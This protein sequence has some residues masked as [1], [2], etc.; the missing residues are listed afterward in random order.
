[1][2]WIDK[3]SPIPL[4][5]QLREAIR[6]E[7]RSARLTPGMMLPTEMEICAQLDISRTTVR[8][9]ILDLA[10]EG[11]LKRIP[12][13]GTFVAES[14]S[15]PD[16]IVI[17]AFAIGD[18]PSPGTELFFRIWDGIDRAARAAGVHVV[19]RRS[20]EQGD[21][22]TEFLNRLSR[23]PSTLGLAIFTWRGVTWNQ[24]RH[25]HNR[26]FPYVLLNRFIPEHPAPSVTLD[27][28][29]AVDQAVRRLH[30][31]GHRR[32]L[33]LGL[34]NPESTAHQERE[35]GYTLAMDALGLHS[36][37]HIA[38]VEWTQST[39]HQALAQLL[40]GRHD[41][42]AVI[43]ASGDVAANLVT[44]A[45]ILGIDIPGDLSIITFDDSSRTSERHPGIT[46]ID[47]APFEFGQAAVDLILQQAS[48]EDG[49]RTRHVIPV[50]FIERGSCA[51]P[52]VVERTGAA[53]TGR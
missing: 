25:L 47:Y 27:D 48:G 9:A 49:A 10:R 24:V 41:Y 32:I 53:R 13:R 22:R 40:G 4:H 50:S 18:S 21:G 11:L 44:E 28:R 34:S 51:P 52:R 23:E 12:A 46:A 15:Q 30:A 6:E 36:Y 1:M 8:A 7:I 39:M 20:I 45:S 26:H 31:L 38:R 2:F 35:Q 17:A 33:Y 16:T 42:T 5:H 43:A 14:T 3:D 37:A 29:A 19:V